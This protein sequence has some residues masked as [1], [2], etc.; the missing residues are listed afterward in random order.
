MFNVLHLGGFG[1]VGKRLP[2]VLHK[3]LPTST[4]ITVT[5]IDRPLVP[6]T[7]I[8]V[9]HAIEYNYIQ[10]HERGTEN[11]VLTEFT[12]NGIDNAGIQPKSLDLIISTSG[13]WMPGNLP[14]GDSTDKDV[15]AFAESY[16]SLHAS[17]VEPAVAAVTLAGKYLKPTGTLVLT[18]AAAAIDPVTDATCGGMLTY[19]FNKAFT[20]TLAEYASTQFNTVIFHPTTINTEANRDAMPDADHSSWNDVDQMMEAVLQKAV[21]QQGGKFKVETKDGKTGLVAV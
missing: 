14:T 5:C 19:G 17:C 10:L 1:A 20:N 12:L 15:I 11:N 13:H 18:G 8:D 6:P 16:A 4:A 3:M 2:A 7:D 21:D 9:P